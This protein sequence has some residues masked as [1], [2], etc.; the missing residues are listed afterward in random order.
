MLFP[1]S[2]SQRHGNQGL[3]LESW[4]L[5]TFDDNLD[6]CANVCFADKF[7]D[8]RDKGLGGGLILKCIWKNKYAGIKKK[9][10]EKGMER[11]FALPDIKT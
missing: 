10:R 4:S 8:S 6:K 2:L 5:C 11:D 1:C 3:P 9:S 7:R